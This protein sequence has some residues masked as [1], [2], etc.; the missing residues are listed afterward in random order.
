MRKIA[1]FVLAGVIGLGFFWYFNSR[2]SLPVL[3]NNNLGI[4]QS[5]NNISVNQVVASSQNNSSVDEHKQESSAAANPLTLKELV[6][7]E[8]A[9]VW[10]EWGEERGYDLDGSLTR[11]YDSLSDEALLALANQNDPKAHL[12]LANRIVAAQSGLNVSHE[13]LAK[14]EEHL[15]DASVLG[16]TSTLATISELRLRGAFQ[17]HKQQK[18]ILAEAYKFLYVGVKR[19]DP[20]S[21]TTL[22]V[23]KKISPIS[24]KE[25]ATI[26]SSADVV[27]DDLSEK[28]KALGLPP[29]DNNVPPEV[30][31]VI[32]RVQ[33][34][35]FKSQLMER[36]H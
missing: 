31:S 1:F 11:S 6:L 30:E 13:A 5:L 23:M 3:N 9:T 4:N 17:N 12:V 26:I 32:K 34:M 28:R 29:F 10:N 35:S 8:E 24:D 22:E 21:A 18:I 2:Q 14:A 16:Y 20:N 19:G 7:P 27:Y 36:K 25:T 33:Q 15:Y